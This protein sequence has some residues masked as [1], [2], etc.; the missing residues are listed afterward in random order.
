MS[1]I[2][3]F[4]STFNHLVIEF[5]Y[6]TTTCYI[7]EFTSELKT[8][9]MPIKLINPESTILTSC[10]L[11]SVNVYKFGLFNFISS[12]YL[13]FIKTD[14]DPN[15]NIINSQYEYSISLIS[16]LKNWFKVIVD[17]N[18]ANVSTT[19]FTNL[20]DDKIGINKFDLFDTDILNNIKEQI[21]TLIDNFKIKTFMIDSPIKVSWL[22]EYATN[23]RYIEMNGTSGILN[24]AIS[25]KFLIINNILYQMYILNY[26]QDDLVL[27]RTDYLNRQDKRFGRKINISYPNL[28][29]ANTGER[30]F[31]TPAEIYFN[32]HQFELEEYN[33]LYNYILTLNKG[34]RKL[35]SIRNQFQ[36]DKR[37]LISKN[38]DLTSTINAAY[39]KIIFLSLGEP[40]RLQNYIN[41]FLSDPEAYF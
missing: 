9:I 41:H 24:L 37:K 39:S 27:D 26:I 38:K 8:A 4:E 6:S 33:K 7:Y 17:Y 10:Q 25:Y 23:I 13:D 19:Y 11:K 2:E 22:I 18:Q 20:E 28:V 40:D 29:I 30:S 15:I 16:H 31:K 1:K 5:G 35:L 3:D 12:I 36:T 14:K 34:N 32:T 21:I